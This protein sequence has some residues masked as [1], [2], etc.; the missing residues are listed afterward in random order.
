VEIRGSASRWTVPPGVSLGVSLDS[1]E[2]L[3]GR[4]FHLY[5]FGWDYEGTVS[6]WDGGR[7]ASLENDS[8]RVLVRVAPADDDS[9]PDA[10]ARSVSGERTFPSDNPVIRRLRPTVYDILLQFGR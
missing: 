10:E 4:P 1:L 2:R 9:V 3:N 6:S 7:L 5:G 8:A